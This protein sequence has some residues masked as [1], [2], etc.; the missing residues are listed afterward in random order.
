[1]IR[2]RVHALIVAAAVLP[3]SAACDV[4]VGKEGFSVDVASGR[5]QDTWTRSYA[6]T[7]GGRLELI[8]TNGRISA[9]PAE[10]DQV[11]LVAERIA[12][13]S[14]D[15]AAQ[16]L[17]KQLDIREETGDSRVRVEVRAPRTFGV[18]GFEVRWTVKVPRGVVV[19]LRTSNGR[20]ALTGLHGEVHAST[21]NGGIEGRG[22]GVTS[23]EATTVNGGVDVELTNALTSA[24]SISLEAV[25]GG[26]ALA[27]PDGSQ[28][29]VVARVTNG[30]ISTT[31]LDFQTTGEQTRRRFE[32][33]L[34]GGGARVTLQTTNGG[35]R[36]SKSTS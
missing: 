4:Q 19:D 10:G 35:V 6:L 26:V 16:E 15:E 25:N 7:A 28:A 24:G 2:S 34:N 31:G 36:L 32:G 22:L 5:A 33:T 9:E 14:T 21:V 11:E 12:K 29:S 27:L 23:L 18:S 30:G 1:M 3:A 20:V 17:M 8:N 13:A